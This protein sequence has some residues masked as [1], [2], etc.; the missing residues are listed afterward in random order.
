[1]NTGITGQP[2]TSELNIPDLQRYRECLEEGRLPREDT[3]ESLLRLRLLHPVS[4]G[5]ETEADHCV[6]VSPRVAVES[7]VAPLEEEQLRLR[8]R[9]G[10]IRRTLAAFE[11][12]HDEVRSRQ[13]VPLT[14]LVGGSAISTAVTGSVR[15]SER[16]VITVQPGGARP[17]ELVGETIDLNMRTL[18][19]GIRQRTLY[20]HS[21]RND[22]ATMEYCRE[23][24]AAGAEIRTVTEIFERLIICDDTVAYIPTSE[25]RANEA[26]EIRH[27]ALIR[28]LRA[29]FE[30]AWEGANP[31]ELTRPGPSRANE[32]AVLLRIARLLVEG[33]TDESISQRLGVSVRTVAK[34]I[35]T[36][37]TRLGSRSRGQL[38]YLIA[39][40]G[41]LDGV[42]ME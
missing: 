5:A 18:A 10:E 11:A 22:P 36:L 23:V 2:M 26:L 16:E 34:R 31:I 20:Q 25:V 21:I 33:H 41:I 17:P 6:P 35:S 9:I 3:P 12:V 29:G 24:V 40:S 28:Y 13:E 38:G 1:M 32:D 7:L 15:S 8:E 30:R 27:P 39:R 14:L 42:Q 37:S 4:E 19:R